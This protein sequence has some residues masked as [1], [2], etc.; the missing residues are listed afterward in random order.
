MCITFAPPKIAKTE[1]M[2]MSVYIY[3]DDISILMP[4]P[5]NQASGLGALVAPFQTKVKMSR[6]N[7]NKNLYL[8]FLHLSIGLDLLAFFCRIDS[9][10]Y[11]LHSTKKTQTQ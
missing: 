9:C 3:E 1:A 6:R 2:D 5:S 7:V 8:S 11:L 4:Y 10:R